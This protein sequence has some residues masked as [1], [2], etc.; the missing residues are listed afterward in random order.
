MAG[1]ASLHLWSFARAC[2]PPSSHLRICVASA[3]EQ[4]CVT[5]ERTRSCAGPRVHVCP[6]SRTSTPRTA[7]PSRARWAHACI[8]ACAWARVC[9]YR[10]AAAAAESSADALRAELNAAKTELDGWLERFRVAAQSERQLSLKL[11]AA[12]RAVQ[13]RPF[14]VLRRRALSD[15][16]HWSRD[17]RAADGQEDHSA[18]AQ[19]LVKG[20]PFD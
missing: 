4:L 15:L 11:S 1:W 16:V 19:S 18:L 20:R 8:C 13:A 3:C 12:E 7:F 6:A 5:Q 10:A 17:D 14:R 9:R 2:T